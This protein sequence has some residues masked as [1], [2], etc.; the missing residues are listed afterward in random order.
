VSGTYSTVAW[1]QGNINADPQFAVPGNRDYHLKAQAG[2]WDSTAQSWVQDALTSPCID[3]GDPNSDWTAEL[4]PHGK[5]INMGAYGGTPQASMSLSAVGNIAD[6]D[7]NDAV[8]RNDL[9]GLAAMWLAQGV[10]LAEDID[11]DGV[12]NFRDLAKLAANWRTDVGSEQEP[13]EVSLGSRAKWSQQYAGYD[14]NLPGY[15]IVGDIASVTMR[16]RTDSLPQTLILAIRTSPGMP[17]MLEGF[18]FAAPCVMVKGEPFKDAE[19]DFFTRPS[20]SMEWQGPSKVQT[21]TYFKF[22]V[23]GDEVHVTLLPLAIELLKVE[24]KISWIDWYR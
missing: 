19:L 15:H 20:S 8:D 1:G 22:N 5:R 6:L 18:T 12:V 13:F 10:L 21:D 4:W 17:P 24:C 14:P 11:R 3:G 9:L 2:R 7:H 23:V 16:A